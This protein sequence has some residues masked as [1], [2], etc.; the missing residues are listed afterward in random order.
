MKVKN[1]N[2]LSKEL[3]RKSPEELEQCVQAFLIDMGSSLSAVP[4][5][6]ASFYVCGKIVLKIIKN[7]EGMLT[8]VQWMS[9]KE[10]KA[11]RKR[12]GIVIDQTA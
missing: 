9:L 11:D 5:G 4:N 1:L 2:R 8:M 10:Y 7:E 3:Q 6:I 12:F